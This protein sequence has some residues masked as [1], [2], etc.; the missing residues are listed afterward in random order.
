[1]STG[2]AFAVA[3]GILPATYSIRT[4]ER[5]L[6]ATYTARPLASLGTQHE[7][8]LRTAASA[9]VQVRTV[10]LI[11]ERGCAALRSGPRFLTR[12]GHR[13]PN[14]GQQPPAVG[15]P[16]RPAAAVSGVLASSRA[17]AASAPLYMRVCLARRHRGRLQ[18]DRM[19]PRVPPL[20]P[21]A[22]GAAAAFTRTKRSS[23]RG[24]P[25]PDRTRARPGCGYLTES[26]L[27]ACSAVPPVRH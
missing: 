25:L 1:M 17:T 18:M 6:V 13:A 24:S 5:S 19:H 4:F 16:L 8:L 22:G 14:S 26:R 3:S 21:P 2:A 10:R 11:T 23:R 15:A 27:E 20:P 7:A 12:A 9:A